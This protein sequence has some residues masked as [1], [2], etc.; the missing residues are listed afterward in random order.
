MARF[1]K[2][3]CGEKTEDIGTARIVARARAHITA[4][5]PLIDKRVL[6]RLLEKKKP[7]RSARRQ[8]VAKR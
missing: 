5:A 8:G 1:Q 3:F 6:D 4:G 7:L 2:T